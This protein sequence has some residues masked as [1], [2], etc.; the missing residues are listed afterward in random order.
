MGRRKKT[1]AEKRE[2]RFRVAFQHGKKKTGFNEEFICTTLGISQ[3]TL[4][5]RKNFPE[6]LNLEEFSKLGVLFEWTDEE[7]MAI[8]RP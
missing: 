3:P 7:M 2:E 8:I 6:K 5:A 4:R 1:E